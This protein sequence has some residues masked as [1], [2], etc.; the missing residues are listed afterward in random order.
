MLLVGCGGQKTEEIDVSALQLIPKKENKIT[1]QTEE[2]KVILPVTNELK[3]LLNKSQLN[4]TINLGKV[5]PFGP[6]EEENESTLKK[7]ENDAI[8]KKLVLSGLLS[9]NKKKYALVNYI[10][11]SGYLTSN[12]QGGV[13][14]DLLPHGVKV[15]E[16]NFKKATLVIVIDNQDYEIFLE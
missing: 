8:L 6:I 2:D 16:I 4:K 15:K 11:K 3:P 13:N 1:S 7:K 10:D 5:N 12:S 9:A 14:T